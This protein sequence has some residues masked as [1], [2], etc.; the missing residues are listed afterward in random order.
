MKKNEFDIFEMLETFVDGCLTIFCVLI[1]LV[2]ILLVLLG[3]VL[4]C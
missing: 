2:M 3:C 1:F 4:W